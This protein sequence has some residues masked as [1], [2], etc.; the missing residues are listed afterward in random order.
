MGSLDTPCAP[1]PELKNGKPVSGSIPTK[2]QNSA[3]NKGDGGI[4]N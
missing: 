3:E 1:Y 2:P 4:Y